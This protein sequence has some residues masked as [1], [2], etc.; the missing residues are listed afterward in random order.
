LFDDLRFALRQ[1]RRSP[2]F[3][4]AVIFTLALGIGV[5]TAVFSMVDGFMLRQLPYAEPERIAALITH[6]EGWGQGRHW[7]EEDAS[8]GTYDWRMVRENVPAATVAAYEGQIDAT[9]SGVNLKTGAE[10]GGVVRFVRATA[11]SS[12]YFDVLGVQPYLGRDFTEDESRAGGPKA[13]ILSYALWQSTFRGDRNVLGKPV[14]VK[15]EPYTIVGVLPPNTVTPNA[16]SN[17]WISLQPGSESGACQGYDCGI[18][19]RLKPGA[20]WQQVQAQLARIQTHSE[21]YSGPRKSW[22][23]AQP[24]Q[25]YVG[26]DVKPKLLGLLMAVASILL[27]GCANL[28]G[29]TLVRISQRA[30]EI[31]TRLALG[32]SR[33]DVLRQLWLENLVLAVVGAAMGLGLAE[34]ILNGLKLFLPASLIPPQGF[35]LDGRVLLFTLVASLLTSLLCG[36][37]PALVT[38]K[39]DLRSSL[40]ASSRSIAGGSGRLRQVLIVA[41]VAITVVLVAGAGLLVRTLAHLET[42]PPGFDAH[43]VMTAKASLDDARYRDA[44]AFQSLLVKSIASMKRIPGVED[45][46]MGLSLPYERGLNL[47]VDIMEGKQA[48]QVYGSSIAYVTPGYFST[49]R[50]PLVGGRAVRENDSAQSELVAVVNESFARKFFGETNVVGRHIRLY[51][52]GKESA[53]N[54]TIV[55]VV[56]DVAKAQGIQSTAPLGTEPVF[57]MPAAQFPSDVLAVAHLWFQPSWIVRTRGPV[58]GLTASMEQA[59]SAADPNLPI[60]GFYSMNDLM[61]QELQTQRVEVLLL[62]TLAGLALLLSAIGIYALVSNLVEQRRREIGIRMALGSSIE[63]AMVHIGLSGIVAASGGLALGAVLSI[64]AL[65]VLKSEVYGIGVYDPVTMVAAPGLLAVIAIAASLLP[66]LRISRIDPAETL[67]SE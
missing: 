25:Q 33:M 11:V 14:D 62:S 10:T 16:S 67:R 32:A 22:L 45:A 34:A 44:S 41:E 39:V 15:G 9:P 30:Q 38:R 21:N 13:V 3:A 18:L 2:G 63:Q 56:S 51:M 59:M 27:I 4:L 12:H 54:M 66:S 58:A 43:N 61:R 8:H 42:L 47:G 46:A 20:T 31:A 6:V 64:F 48:G 17:L 49:L 5:N 37:L 26:A 52:G 40:A 53:P 19:M 50:M 23:Y 65:R 24:L 29:L 1:L 55:G 60:S 36:A 35:A 57:Y 7:S 28:A